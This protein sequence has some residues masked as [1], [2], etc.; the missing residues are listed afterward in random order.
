MDGLKLEKQGAMWSHVIMYKENKGTQPIPV[1]GN[2]DLGK[3]L[4]S[5]LQTSEKTYSER[6]P[7]GDWSF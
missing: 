7:A 6:S 4:E 1:H 3:G 5:K 2:R